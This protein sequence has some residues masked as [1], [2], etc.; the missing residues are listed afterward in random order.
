[1]SENKKELCRIDTYGLPVLEV[2][3][4]V[5]WDDEL[6]LIKSIAP[7]KS[8]LKEDGTVVKLLGLDVAIEN[9]EGECIGVYDFD[10]V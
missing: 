3:K 2:G 5:E 6:W 8:L 1:M 9:E 10:F 7:R 4:W